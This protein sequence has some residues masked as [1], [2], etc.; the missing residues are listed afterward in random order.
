MV[1]F[2]ERRNVENITIFL[3]FSLSVP[4]G[5]HSSNPAPATGGSAV[6]GKTRKSDPKSV[7]HQRQKGAQCGGIKTAQAAEAPR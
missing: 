3:D 1:F 4:K 6:W 7:P 5:H 2:Y